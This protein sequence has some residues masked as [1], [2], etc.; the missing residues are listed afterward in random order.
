MFMKLTIL[1]FIIWFVLPIILLAFYIGNTTLSNVKPFIS[2]KYPLAFIGAVI[3]FLG[4]FMIMYSKG[5]I[6][7][8]ND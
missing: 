6:W 5:E 3:I 2:I 7:Y 4:L 1:Q 8:I